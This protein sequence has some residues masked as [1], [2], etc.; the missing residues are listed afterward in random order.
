M[1]VSLTRGLEI[2]GP[3]AY[4]V[5]N[6]ELDSI[7]YPQ[8]AYLN[9]L[10][11]NEDE[12]RGCRDTH[13]LLPLPR[14]TLR[15]LSVTYENLF[16]PNCTCARYEWLA[17]QTSDPRYALIGLNTLFP[18]LGHEWEY[19]KDLIGK[20]DQRYTIAS[21]KD[22]VAASLVAFTRMD[23]VLFPLQ[24]LRTRDAANEEQQFTFHGITRQELRSP[25]GHR[26]GVGADMNGPVG[27]LGIVDVR[28]L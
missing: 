12:L 13:I 20:A 8:N 18:S 9:F 15:G 24:Y 1:S 14:M 23:R 19:Q 17:E 11:I 2:M 28:Y 3:N 5:T 27:Y 26:M 22:L 7:L 4:G 6:H 10:N 21:V 16:R 25:D